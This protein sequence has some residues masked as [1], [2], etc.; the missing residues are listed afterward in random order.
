MV[1]VK[2]TMKVEVTM[3]SPLPLPWEEEILMMRCN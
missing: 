3:K 2:V 1:K